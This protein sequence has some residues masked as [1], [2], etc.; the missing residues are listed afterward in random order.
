MRDSQLHSLVLA[1]RSGRASRE[2]VVE[3]VAG[4]MY[5]DPRRYGFD[6][7]DAAAEALERHGGRIAAL[8]DRFEDRGFDFDVYLRTS[9]RYLART[10]RRERRRSSE[11]ELACEEAVFERP[12]EEE[13]EAFAIMA[14]ASRRLGDGRSSR[15]GLARESAYLVTERPRA[16]APIEVSALASR[17]VFLALKCAWDMDDEL[18]ARVAEA[19]G[20]D[21][22]WL[23]DALAQARRSLEPER[24][25]HERLEAWRNGCWC[26]LRLLETKLK[27][28]VEGEKRARLA[29]AAEREK[30]RLARARA[31][32]AA[33]RP[34]VPNSVVARILGVPK[35]TVD[36]GLYYLRRRSEAAEAKAGLAAEAP[37]RLSSRDGTLRRDRQRP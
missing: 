12:A 14:R 4:L 19:G 34:V 22:S 15:E 20:V 28:E 13:G 37:A 18:A 26:R 30:A 23:G 9:L 5:R 8:A 36:S 21:P 2:R 31:E 1:Y 29:E 27:A 6:D 25:R 24:C 33:F 11:R 7:E 35:G 17:V 32:I 16:L 10:I 3:R